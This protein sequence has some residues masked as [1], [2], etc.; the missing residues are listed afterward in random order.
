M[1]QSIRQQLKAMGI[2]PDRATIGRSVAERLGSINGDTVHADDMPTKE[3]W[4][5]VRRFKSKTE[6]LFAEEL[7]RKRI[8]REITRWRYEALRFQLADHN[9]LQRTYTPDFVCWWPR[10]M[11]SCVEVK[12]WREQESDQDTR[13][14]L[15]WARQQYAGPLLEFRAFRMIRGGGWT[16]IWR[17]G[18]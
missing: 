15:A 16:E 4:S 3:K 14:V 2:D 11:L 1:T 13:T 5:I 9:E 12:H 17:G 7:E 6:T 8:A 10:G 18:A